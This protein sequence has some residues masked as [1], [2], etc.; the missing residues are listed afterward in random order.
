MA[1][2]PYHL[3]AQRPPVGPGPWHVSV[4]ATQ[5]GLASW[6]RLVAPGLRWAVAHSRRIAQICLGGELGPAGP[7]MRALQAPSVSALPHRERLI[8]VTRGPMARKKQSRVQLLVRRQVVALNVGGEAAPA[9]LERPQGAAPLARSQRAL[10]QVWGQPLGAPFTLV[11]ARTR[12]PVVAA[13]L[14]A[15]V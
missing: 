4:R 10:A 15:W 11:G 7:R 5:P 9:R 3:Y 6:W 13:P 1:P 2:C 12:W 8:T 14:L